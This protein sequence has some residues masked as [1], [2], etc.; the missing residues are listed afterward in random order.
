MFL[1][2]STKLLY[3]LEIID[4]QQRQ[5]CYCDVSCNDY[6]I[7]ERKK[8]SKNLLPDQKKIIISPE[9]KSYQC[10]SQWNTDHNVAVF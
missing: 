6:K 10:L 3:Y 5:N 8:Y 2:F 1:L 4:K 9:K 7:G